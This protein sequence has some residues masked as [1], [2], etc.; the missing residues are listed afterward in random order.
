M[1]KRRVKSGLLRANMVGHASGV[2]WKIRSKGRF[3]PRL[4]RTAG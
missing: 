1:L 3:E 4:T 2:L